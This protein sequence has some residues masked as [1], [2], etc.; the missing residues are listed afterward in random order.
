MCVCEVVLIIYFCLSKEKNVE[1]LKTTRDERCRELQNAMYTMQI[2][3]EEQFQ[4]K[5]DDLNGKMIQISCET[6][7]IEHTLHDIEYQISTTSKAEIISKQKD[8]LNSIKIICRKPITTFI[9]TPISY[10]FPR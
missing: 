6:E 2:K 3:L 5:F 7:L 4:N 1:K 9:P 10:D 8:L